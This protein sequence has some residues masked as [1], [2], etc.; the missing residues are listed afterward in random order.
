MYTILQIFRRDLRR[1]FHSKFAVIVLIGV[2]LIPSLYAWFNIAANLDPYSN[3]KN[4]KVGV[5]NEDEGTTLDQ[6]GKLNAGQQIIDQL[7]KNDQL[8]WQFVSA[9]EAVE[10]AKSGKYYAAI[11][12]PKEFSA[13]LGSILKDDLTKPQIDY[14]INEKKNAIAPKITETGAETIAGQVNETFL[15][16]AAE[17]VSDVLMKSVGGLTADIDQSTADIMSRMQQIEKNLADYQTALG[18]TVDALNK[19]SE[20]LKDADLGLDDLSKLAG[21]S[22]QLLS[23]SL[24]TLTKTR[25]DV[26]SFTARANADLTD[27]G[28]VFGEIRG[29]SAASLGKITGKA[30][31][32]TESIGGALGTMQ[33][34]LGYNEQILT[35]LR[36]IAGQWTDGDTLTEINRVISELEARNSKGEETLG[37]LQTTNSAAADAIRTSTDAAAKLDTMAGE[38]K[39]A[40]GRTGDDFTKNIFPQLT[41]SLD[42]FA[43][44]AGSLSGVLNSV[45]PTA[46][47]VKAIGGQLQQT[48]KDTAKALDST[49]SALAQ[50]QDQIAATRTDLNMLHSSALYQELSA[51]T[52][53]NQ[54]SIADFMAQPVTV[55]TQ[56]FYPVDNYGSGMA[57]FYTNL[58]IWVGGIVLIAIFKLEVDRDEK[59]PRFT[60]MQGY[61]GR[62]LLFVAVGLVQAFI[63]C[64][65]DLLLIGIQCV[66][67]AAFIGA[68]LLASFVYA[69]IIYALSIAFKHIGKAICVIL[70]I[71]QIP[72]SSGTYP[73]EMTPEFFQKLHPLLPFTYSINAMREAIAG[74]YGNAYVVSLL[75]LLVFLPAALLVGLAV[76]RL[77]LNP[78]RLFDEKLRDTDLMISEEYSMEDKR[79][80]L[81]MLL[82]MAA[83]KEGYHRQI[84]QQADAFEAHYKK[85]VRGGFLAILIL[86]LIFLILMFSLE[87]KLV[88]LVLWITSIILTAGFLIIVEYLHYSLQSRQ[89]ASKMSTAEVVG[90]LKKEQEAGK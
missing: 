9:K 29:Q 87:S 76:R 5:A 21:Q 79:F 50:V 12:I 47:Q 17:T 31:E 88:F 52:D 70:V 72:G 73:I 8:G 40:L 46:E 16:V 28:K 83:D 54:S 3:T 41:Q 74:M 85:L 69:N 61:F 18:K 27:A 77:L 43:G 59:I 2:C 65:G 7:K 25:T 63:V 78:N 62:W 22:S 34:T 82:S 35:N 4:I 44:T 6:I 38:Q 33:E 1:I 51:L 19:G 14:Y 60:A 49:K 84:S 24:D 55:K 45:G 37:Y 56:N 39:Q 64:L 20:Q 48:L 42:A 80:S 15:S 11:V 75:K 53:L 30:T 81:G 86:P 66:H 32:A 23:G 68:G 90:S 57:P 26:N 58:A 13:D 67:P 10:G 71:I 89:K 36:T